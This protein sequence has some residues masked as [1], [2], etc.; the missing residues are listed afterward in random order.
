VILKF[1]DWYQAHYPSNKSSAKQLNLMTSK[2]FK[3][4]LIIASLAF[5]VTLTGCAIPEPV[6]WND[7]NTVS[8]RT[9]INHDDFKKVTNY[10][11]PDIASGFTALYTA[12]FLR[13]WKN[14]KTG[15]VQYQIY[16]REWYSGDWRFYDTAYD[17][18]GNKLDVTVID[19]KVNECERSKCYYHEDLGLNVSRDYLE[20]SRESG[21]KFKVSGK[22]GEAVEFLPP[23]YIQGF[24]S[25]IKQQ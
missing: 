18:N 15:D 5:S 19:R 9:V 4:N 14:D 13:A 12:L 17:S 2:I 23:G 1:N 8:T 22:G 24:L 11:G 21:V 20:K 25:T 3:T 16:D 10:R 7:P 6:N